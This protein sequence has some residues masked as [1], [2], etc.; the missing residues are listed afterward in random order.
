MY[1]ANGNVLTEGSHTLHVGHTN[2]EAEYDGFLSGVAAGTTYLTQYGTMDVR[3]DSNLV[4]QQVN[5]S[6][7]ARAPNMTRLDVRARAMWE[8]LEQRGSTLQHVLREDN[9]R[10]DRL[11]SNAAAGNPI[12][13]PDPQALFTIRNPTDAQDGDTEEAHITGGT[14]VGWE[15]RTRGNFRPLTFP[16]V[17]R[18]VRQSLQRVTHATPP[19]MRSVRHIR[20]PTVWRN[21]DAA[22]LS[23]EHRSSTWS[24][25]YGIRP[26]YSFGRQD[27][28][29]VNCPFCGP[30][31]LAT[32]PHML[33]CP[34]GS[35]G[36]PLDGT[37]NVLVGGGHG[38]F[39]LGSTLG[40]QGTNGN[41]K[42]PAKHP[43]TLAST[44]VLRDGGNLG[45]VQG[46]P[47]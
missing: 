18:I 39:D 23:S 31:T 38:D 41:P 13:A 44:Q 30:P 3:G 35:P 37:T 2:N 47:A 10:A 16:C 15:V 25:L 8:P 33:E 21:L 36:P 22:T 6:W 11:A 12:S 17:L 27:G 45:S 34:L 14:L 7:Q 4:L 29:K 9:K 5:G 24:I 28:D 1:S 46:S 40:I 26:R 20:W 32:A 19:R 43:K 42:T